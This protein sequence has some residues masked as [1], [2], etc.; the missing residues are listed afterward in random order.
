MVPVCD[1]FADALHGVFECTHQLFGR[2][3]LDARSAV[4]ECVEDADEWDCRCVS[5]YASGGDED[6]RVVEAPRSPPSLCILTAIVDKV[7]LNIEV[8]IRPWRVIAHF[9]EAGHDECGGLYVS[10]C[11]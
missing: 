2:Y 11:S 8:D 5:G 4:G 7:L 9:A 6:R 3:D 10:V 1:L